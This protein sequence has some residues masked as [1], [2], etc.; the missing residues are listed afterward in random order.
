VVAILGPRQCGKTTL[1]RE[2]FRQGQVKSKKIFFRDL[3]IF[4]ALLN[5]HDYK[6]LL[7]NPKLGASWEGYALESVI[8]HL[9]VDHQDCYFWAV[10]GQGELDLLIVRGT[11]RIGFEFKYS[12]TPHMTPA[13]DMALDNLKLRLFILVIN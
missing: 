11:E 12:K 8:R 6:T 10:H 1:A 9:K 4:H 2:Y 7:T 13:I 3:G 5:I